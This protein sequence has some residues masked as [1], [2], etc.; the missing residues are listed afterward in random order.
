MPL[1]PLDARA[2]SHL[3]AEAGPGAIPR[4]RLA[5]QR[6]LASPFPSREAPRRREADLGLGPSPY[7]PQGALQG[8][9]EGM[10]TCRC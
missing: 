1:W 9:E 7:G 6:G 4:R 3:L 8:N 5:A 10:A 2:W